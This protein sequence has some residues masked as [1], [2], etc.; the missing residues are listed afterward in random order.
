MATHLTCPKENNCR[1]IWNALE[2]FEE[3]D[4]LKNVTG[5]QYCEMRE[6]I[7]QAEKIVQEDE[8]NTARLKEMYF[9]LTKK[10][11]KEAKRQS[12]RFM[13]GKAYKDNEVCIPCIIVEIRR[14]I[15]WD[16][17]IEGKEHF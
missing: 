1:K 5:A 8:E 3:S 7:K 13:L 12:T 6:K 11:R 14:M 10:Q 4:L 9:T 17:Q 15:E 16:T 2:I